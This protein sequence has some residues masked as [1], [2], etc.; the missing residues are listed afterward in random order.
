MSIKHNFY[1]H[2]CNTRGHHD[3]CESGCHIFIKTVLEM[4]A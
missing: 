4:W 1:V 3:I 2:K